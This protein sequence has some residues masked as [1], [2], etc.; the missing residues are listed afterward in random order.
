MFFTIVLSARPLVT[1][2]FTLLISALR[3]F[4]ISASVSDWP[5]SAITS[6]SGVTTSTAS[7]RRVG[8][9]PRSIASISS[10]RST[11]MYDAKTFTVSMPWRRRRL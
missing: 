6:P 1:N 10:R 9:S 2:T 7:V 4:L 3:S 5:A 11:V 8:R